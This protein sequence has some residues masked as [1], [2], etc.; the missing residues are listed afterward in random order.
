VAGACVTILKAWFDGDWPIPRPVIPDATGTTLLAYN[1]EPLTVANELDKLAA[2]VA[3]GRNGAG[4]HYR[5]DYWESVKLG[6]KIAVG[7]LEE[8][9]ETYR[10]I[11]SFSF[12]GFEG[13]TIT[14]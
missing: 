11:C 6:E 10:E 2:N 8:Q 12:R 3:I 1:G 7:I 14:I 9:R 13:Q 5:S 4:F